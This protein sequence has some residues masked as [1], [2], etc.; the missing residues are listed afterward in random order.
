MKGQ[1]RRQR[2][3]VGAADRDPPSSDTAFAD[4]KAE[5]QVTIGR[6]ERSKINLSALPQGMLIAVNSPSGI[7]SSGSAAETI[8]VLPSAVKKCSRAPAAST[9]SPKS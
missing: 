1:A 2:R 6:S 9:A 7:T 8:L 4:V 3:G 5:G